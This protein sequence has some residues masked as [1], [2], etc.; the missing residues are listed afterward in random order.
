[1][2]LNNCL[3]KFHRYLNILKLKK[4]IFLNRKTYNIINTI[5]HCNLLHLMF[6]KNQF[7]TYLKFEGIIYVKDNKYFQKTK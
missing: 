7:L 3:N 5:K 4:I 2:I 6:Q 1:M